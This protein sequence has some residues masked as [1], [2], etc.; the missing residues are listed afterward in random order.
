MNLILPSSPSFPRAITVF[1]QA[2]KIGVEAYERDTEA[3]DG[4]DGEGSKDSRRGEDG[5]EKRGKGTDN[6]KGQE[7]TLAVGR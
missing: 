4:E 7:Q 2:G 6:G 5:E 3:S 1:P